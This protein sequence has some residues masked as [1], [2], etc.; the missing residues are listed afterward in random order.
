MR[1]RIYAGTSWST[2]IEQGDYEF[3]LLPAVGH[4]L[5]LAAG[6]RGR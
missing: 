4:K 3:D 1:V 6:R 2:A 5:A